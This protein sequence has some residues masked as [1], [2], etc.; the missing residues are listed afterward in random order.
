MND[1]RLGIVRLPLPDG[2]LIPLQLT[3]AALDARGHDWVLEQFRLAQKGKAGSSSAIAELLEMLSGGELQASV[4][5][6]APAAE[7]PLSP[8]LKALWAT[9]ELG[10]HGPAG[11]PAEEGPANPPKSVR[12][13]WWRRVFGPRSATA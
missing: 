9:W 13:T 10:Q 2:R 12:Q 5:M 7:Y 6:A 11:R 3:Y 1:A 8:T 4:V